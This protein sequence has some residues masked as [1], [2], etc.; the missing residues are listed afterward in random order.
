MKTLIMFILC[1]WLLPADVAGGVH[2]E[3]WPCYDCLADCERGDGAVCCREAKK[4]CCKDCRF[5]SRHYQ[6]CLDYVDSEEG[7][8]ENRIKGKIDGMRRRFLEETD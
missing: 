6:Q 7:Y 1:F 5:T 2:K 3:C 8:E 4:E